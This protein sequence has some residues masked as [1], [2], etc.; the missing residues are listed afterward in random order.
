MSD[1]MRLRRAD[2]EVYLDRRGFTLPSTWGIFLH[3]M[4]APDPGLDLHDHPWWFVSFI[5]AGGYTEERAPVRDAP[6]YAEWAERFPGVCTRGFV[7]RRRRWSF[8]VMRLDECHRITELAGRHCWTLVL[9]GPRRQKWGFY[10]PNGWM[11]KD[12]YDQ[13]VR[14]ER[15]DLFPEASNVDD[16][17]AKVKNR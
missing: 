4:D 15:R 5:I 16:P 9:H 17:R 3:R 12:K 6:S 13:T 10:L 8:K 1:R 14:A 2:G 11:F 7:E